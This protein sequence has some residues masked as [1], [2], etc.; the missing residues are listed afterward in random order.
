MG[1]VRRFFLRCVALFRSGRAERDLAREIDAHLR[2]L[3]DQFVARGMSHTDARY[4]AKRAFGGV[5]QAK[6]HHR[7]SRSF[8]W[9]AGWPMDLRLG[10]RMLIKYPGL[11]VVAVIAL[12]MAIGAGASYMEF[13]TDLLHPTLPF[14]DGHRIAGIVNWDVKA[15]TPTRKSLYDFTRWRGEV[16]S[17]V[18]LGAALSLRRNLITED[19]RSEPVRGAEITASAFRVIPTPPLMGRTL[20]DDDEHPAAPPVAVIGEDLWQ[21]RFNSDP[22]ILGRTIRLARASYTVVGVMPR[23]FGFPTSQSLW[24]PLRANA[25][26][27]RPGEGPDIIIFG[28]LAPGIDYG[29]AQAELTAVAE[30]VAAGA[31]K[32][33]PRLRPVIKPY[34]TSMWSASS[35]G[36]M[37]RLILYGANLL[38]LGLLGIC[39]ANV[40]TLVFARTVTREAEITVRT[41]LGASRGRIVSQ[42]FA[43]ALVPA[44]IA[45][46]AGLAIAAFGS[47]WAK[48]KFVEAQNQ[49]P[50]F[51][52]SAELSTATWIYAGL[53]ALLAAA[54]VGIIPALK[55]TGPQMQARLKS[56][57]AAG[58]G[59]RFGGVWT[60]VIIG[61]VAVTILF[62][63][64]V[65]SIGWNAYA[66][67]RAASHYAFRAEDYLT[68]RLEM[69][70]DSTPAASTAAG[71][72]AFRAQFKTA[73]QE[74][75]RRLELD[76]GVAAVTHT[77]R[78]PGKGNMFF[79][80]VDSPEALRSRAADDPLW[81]RSGI[82]GADYFA[83]LDAPIVSGRAFTSA[84][85]ELARPVAVVDETFVRLIMGGRDPVGLR[86]REPQNTEN[87]QTGPWYEIVGVVK[88]LTR[89]PNKTTEHAMLYLPGP[90]G[91][92]E[93]STMM[94]VRARGDATLLPATVGRVGAEA[95][96]TMRLYDVRPLNQSHREDGMAFEFF[97]RVFT[98]VSAVA[99]L[100]SSAGVYS[101]LSFT[102]SSRTREIG[103]RVALGAAPR[104]IVTAI[105]SR[106]FAQ[107]GLGIL[108]G[109]VPG[110]LLV[111]MGA[112]EVAQGG[113][114]VVALV[115]TLAVAVFIA[116]VTV[117]ACVG[118][119]RRA[120]R[121]QPTV[122]LRAE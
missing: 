72:A 34:V 61:Q 2:L 106:S 48:A 41:A 98:V 44:S 11:T 6:E 118:P 83:A 54:V 21:K 77:T 97:L 29:G 47:R 99:L 35:D 75:E 17:V 65:V 5:E 58:P 40:A 100:L 121:I 36:E 89:I 82:V 26:E 24:V 114:T 32:E 30:R 107:I 92:A 15:G 64:S 63:M 74:M 85:A 115:A 16:T 105:F 91:A 90:P 80:E 19:G 102:L 111:S 45:A 84:E 39:G 94:V 66:V 122:A 109:S 9:L 70:R 1:P 10:A 14:K 87:P 68:L 86:V 73:F 52:W 18:D 27:H 8:R 119:A 46:G 76:P 38:F 49:A 88:D 57:G 20:T 60:A 50:P 59:L 112:P 110:F 31:P 79:V 104:S 53:L 28:R 33:A 78:L 23:S 51:W 113:G 69:D 12:S 25:T 117:L 116:G 120:L 22:A 101:L 42:L 108:A 71:S 43:E 67:P 81:V 103:I 93:G 4:A 56:A 96:P 37:Q 55:A 62:L 13:V 95:D 7:D 3:E